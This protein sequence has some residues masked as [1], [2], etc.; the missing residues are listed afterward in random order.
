ME[1]EWME[2]KEARKLANGLELKNASEWFKH[3]KG[4]SFAFKVPRN[5]DIVYKKEWKGYGD[6][7]GTGNISNHK[8]NFISFKK[9]RKFA[10][11]LKL[12]STA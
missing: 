12:R 1:T 4:K 8:K 7:L 2:F 10:I 5:P 9:A 11:S 3:I 6:W